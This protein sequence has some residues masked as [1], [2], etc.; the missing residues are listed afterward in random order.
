MID[1][2][3]EYRT[4]TVYEK[5]VKQ[6]AYEFLI[7]PCENKH[8][9]IL[10]YNALHSFQRKYFIASNKYGFLTLHFHH[11][12]DSFTLFSL[13]LI[14]QV[15]KNVPPQDLY[16]TLN[17]PEEK[18]MLQS[19]DF[20]MDHHS[21]LQKTHLVDLKPAD[22]PLD[23]L[24]REDELL[25][26]YLIRLNAAIHSLLNYVPGITDTS[27]TAR[28]A[29]Q[30][31]QGVCQDY[32]HIMI[33][34]LRQQGLPARYVAGY[35]SLSDERNDSQLHAWVE[36]YL[37]GLGWRGFDPTNNLQENEHFIKIAHGRDYLDCQPIKGVLVTEGG[38]QTSYEVS[39]RNSR[40][41]NWFLQEQQQQ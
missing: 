10:H 25:G 8:Q 5:P 27:T 30:G 9:K 14:A 22:F 11:N 20:Q 3:I 12:N 4:K 23:L 16:S 35:L 7:L 38:H 41:Y 15:A 26:N 28:L 29:L 21:F 39:V 31:R 40:D 33:G 18:D 19:A 17:V 13:S 2:V 34:I 24:R 32:A 37:P 1:Y 6:A 36:V